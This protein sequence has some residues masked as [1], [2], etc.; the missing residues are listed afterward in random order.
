M[1]IPQ[2]GIEMSAVKSVPSVSVSYA[3]NGSFTKLSESGTR[4]NQERAHE[5]DGEQSL[6]IKSTIQAQS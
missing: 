4:A 1:A 2:E 3:Q 5:R 6:L